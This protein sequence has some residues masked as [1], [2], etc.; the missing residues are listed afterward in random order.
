MNKMMIVAVALLSGSVAFAQGAP[1]AGK[2]PAAEKAPAADKAPAAGPHMAAMAMPRPRQEAL[3]PFVHN[4]VSTGTVVAGGMGPGSPEM[5]TKGKATC[6][7]LP[8]NMW[9]ACDI[10]DTSGTGK[11]AM[12]WM[13]HWVFGYD[14]IAKG[15]RGV[16]TDNFGMM[17]R[18]KGTL[19]GTKMTWETMDEMKIPNMPSK[20]RVSLDAADPKNIKFT[21]EVFMGGKWM[22]RSTAVHKTAAGK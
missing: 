1:A 8:G 12:H 10:E 5:T 9:A 14:N 20:S 3:K 17:G 19:E 21:E 4:I 16:M 15:Y 22:P 11:Q 18:M 6:K 7:W 13:G 2:A